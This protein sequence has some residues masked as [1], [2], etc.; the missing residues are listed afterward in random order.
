MKTKSQK[1]RGTRSPSRH[2]YYKRLEE[3][4]KMQ[5]RYERKHPKQGG[6]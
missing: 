5:Q 1:S 3:G 2:T 4:I 6:K